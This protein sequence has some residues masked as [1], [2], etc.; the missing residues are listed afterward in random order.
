[1]L[2]SAVFHACGVGL[3]TAVL[4]TSVQPGCQ[5][6]QI[7]AADKP[8]RRQSLGTGLSEEPTSTQRL[9]ADKAFLIF[10]PSFLQ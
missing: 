9:A 5:E 8:K 6:Q 10:L 3:S 7:G 1:M 4:H 2:V